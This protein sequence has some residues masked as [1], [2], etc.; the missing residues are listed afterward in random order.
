M[1]L[2]QIDKRPDFSLNDA[3]TQR[4]CRLQKDYRWIINHKKELRNEYPNQY[5]AVENESVR[6]VA[7]TIEALMSSISRNNEQVDNFAI[8]YLSQYPTSLLF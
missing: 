7:N 6:Y 3:L 4:F 2:V 1:T 8:E 5:V